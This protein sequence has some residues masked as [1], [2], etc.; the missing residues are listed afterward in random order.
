MSPSLPPPFFFVDFT[1]FPDLTTEI[2]E[3][4]PPPRIGPIGKSNGEKKE[5]DPKKK[6]SL[7]NLKIGW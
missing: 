4:P 5:V 6:I 7:A 3:T 2:F 1:I